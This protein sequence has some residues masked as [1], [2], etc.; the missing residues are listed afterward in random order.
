VTASPS[1]M[2]CTMSAGWTCFSAVL[3]ASSSSM[4]KT[5]FGDRLTFGPPGSFLL[6][7][8]KETHL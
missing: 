5:K 8:V 6:L 1:G 4:S 2:I 3:K 7:S